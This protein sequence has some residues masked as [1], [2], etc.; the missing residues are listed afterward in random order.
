MKIHLNIILSSMPGSPE[1]SLFLR[2]PHQN[3][4]YD[5]PAPHLSYMLPHLILLGFIN[6]TI[7]GE[8]YRS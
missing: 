4:V 5:S 7:V 3:P 8:K 2:F 1:W 6:R